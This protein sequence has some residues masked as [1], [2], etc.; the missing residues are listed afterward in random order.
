MFPNEVLI[1]KNEKERLVE[2]VTE[3]NKILE[4][5]DYSSDYSYRTVTCMSRVK[6]L[7]K[8]F[9]QWCSFLY[10]KEDNPELLKGD[11]DNEG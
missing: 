2:L 6:T 10:T 11:K 4:K 1:N 5:Y 3:A 9:L 7:G 8:E